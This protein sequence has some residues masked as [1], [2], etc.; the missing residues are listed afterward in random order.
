MRKDAMNGI[1]V[2][3]GWDE[4]L[5]TPDAAWLFL[6]ILALVIVVVVFWSRSLRPDKRKHPDKD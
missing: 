5:H 2:I 6:L 4:W 1:S 3:A